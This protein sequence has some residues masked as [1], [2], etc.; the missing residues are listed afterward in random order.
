MLTYL[1]KVLSPD[2]RSASVYVNTKTDI[3]AVPSIMYC[4]SSTTVYTEYSV[5]LL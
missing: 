1:L 4:C 5:V 2:I 3:N